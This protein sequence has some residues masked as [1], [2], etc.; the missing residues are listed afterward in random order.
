MTFKKIFRIGG[1]VALP[2]SLSIITVSCS[3]ENESND[4]SDY[5]DNGVALTSKEIAEFAKHSFKHRQDT[6]KKNDMIDEFGANTIYEA[7]MIRWIDGDTPIVNMTNSDGEVHADAHIRIQSI[8]TP[9]LH[10]MGNKGLINKLTTGEEFTWANKAKMFGEK[11]IPVGTKLLVYADGTKSYHRFVGSLFYKKPSDTE[12]HNY[13]IELLQSGLTNVFPPSS[14]TALIKNPFYK[15]AGI[16][17]ADA[18]NYALKKHLGLFSMTKKHLAEILGGNHG[19]T[20]D[21]L[22]RY[23]IPDPQNTSMNY[24][25]YLT[26]KGIKYE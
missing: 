18:Y 23:R 5:V 9:E 8:D 16:A 12:Y 3:S 25:E 1:I 14:L 24:Y 17:V 2:L 13:S 21:E 4:S 10:S 15:L 7:T 26:K 6:F 22:V 11:V 20:N 19:I